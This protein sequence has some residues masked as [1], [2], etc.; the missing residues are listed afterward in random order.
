MMNLI[1]WIALLCIL[2]ALSAQWLI[3]RRKAPAQAG[4]LP[5][6]ILG[7]A[8][9]ANWPLSTGSWSIDDVDFL[10]TSDRIRAV[11]TLRV[12]RDQRKHCADAMKQ[13]ARAIYAQTEVE[14]VLIEAYSGSLTPALYLFA[15]DGRGWWGREIASTAYR[16][17]D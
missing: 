1:F 9:E 4:Q 2:F 17:N 5:A 8:N 10:A 13:L 11:V 3:H 16:P 15:A 6:H 12:E 14:A 7:I